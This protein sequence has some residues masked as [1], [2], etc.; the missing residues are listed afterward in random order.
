MKSNRLMSDNLVKTHFKM[1]KS[2]KLW[3]VSGM[4]IL[5]LGLGT[6]SAVADETKASDNN[7]SQASSDEQQP[8]FTQKQAV[9]TTDQQN[10]QSSQAQVDES[11]IASNRF[12]MSKSSSQSI[13][14]SSVTSTSESKSVSE[15]ESA[16]LSLNQSESTVDLSK[17]QQDSQSIVAPESMS[18]LSNSLL[19]ASV[20]SG[21]VNLVSTEVINDTATKTETDSQTLQIQSTSNVESQTVQ[22]VQ[23]LGQ[24]LENSPLSAPVIPEL[25]LANRVTKKQVAD[26]QTVGQDSDSTAPA[27]AT[28]DLLTRDAVENDI[29]DRAASSA[30]DENFTWIGGDGAARS[31]W[32]SS[33]STKL[34]ENTGDLLAKEIELTYEGVQYNS[35]T[36]K[37]D[38]TFNYG[39]PVVQNNGVKRYM[40]F[41]F[42]L[43]DSIA[44][45][46]SNI[47]ANFEKTDHTLEKNGNT[48]SIQFPVKSQ[49]GGSTTVTVSL[50]PVR[51]T[52]GDWISGYM[53]SNTTYG[54][55]G[56]HAVRPAFSA[57]RNLTY[58]TATKTGEVFGVSLNKDLLNKIQTNAYPQIDNLINLEKSDKDDFNKQIKAVN[59]N[60]D[61]SA[62]IKGIVQHAQ[63]TDLSM[64]NAAKDSSIGIINKL[65]DLTSDEKKAYISSVQQ[66]TNKRNTAPISDAATL[67]SL[68]NGLVNKLSEYGKTST[69]A[70]SALRGLTSD[71]INS[72]NKQIN[73]IVTNQ[74]SNIKKAANSNDA[75]SLSI[76]G[77]QNI[78]DIVK[79]QQQISDK[80]IAAAQKAITDESAKVKLDIAKDVTLTDGEKKAQQ[81]N[82]DAEA[83]KATDAIDTAQNATAIQAAKNTGVG[84]IDKQHKPGHALDDQKND[85]KQAIETAKQAAIDKIN[86]DKTLTDAAK[87]AQR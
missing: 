55:G 83:K 61:F 29:S 60:Q 85:A 65:P 72:A 79:Q 47:V 22:K 21:V 52:Q 26:T 70:I 86:N 38:V 7:A 4:S 67:Q 46:T 74:I 11:T 66:Q 28:S 18:Q 87:Q 1:Y 48:Y 16:S 23:T 15:S 33:K 8:S 42:E 76:S 39:T 9:L 80:F 31:K 2:G 25:A 32:S 57:V 81:N 43:S 20:N 14:K 37:Y 62:V 40:V 54:G 44:Q 71:Q 56:T 35:Q 17:K 49:V 78:A 36:G 51:L 64:L 59:I 5:A 53:E 75:Q 45:K 68:K 34:D 30:P 6:T 41:K 69:T 3:L 58:N 12:S 84:N 73:E 82:V 50:D 24:V 10:S 63:D 13:S 27:I 19:S 77:Q